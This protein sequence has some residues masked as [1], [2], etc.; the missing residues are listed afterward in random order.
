[1]KKKPCVC[2]YCGELRKPTKDHVIPKALF[3]KPYPLNMITVPACEDCNNAKSRDDDFLRDILTSDIYGSQSMEAQK[4]F[5][6]KVLSS[7]NQNSSD[8]ARLII[9]QGRV[10]PF[11]S[12]G[13]IQLDSL[14]TAP[15]DTAR[16]DRIFSTLIRGLYYDARKLYIPKGYNFN[17]MRYHPREFQ[18]VYDELSATLKMRNPRIL[19]NI[20]G[21]TYTCAEE[22]PLTTIWLLWF[23][24]NVCFSVSSINPDFEKQ[25]AAIDKPT[26]SWGMSP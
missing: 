10:E 17:V 5:K 12:H 16:I 14:P 18:Q 15:L 13:G 19:G 20:F 1:M 24:N 4:V 25:I 7:V 6:S 8:F 2:T 22:D 23:Y 26:R 3:P 11:Y 9:A 21:A